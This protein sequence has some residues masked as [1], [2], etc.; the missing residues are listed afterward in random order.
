MWQDAFYLAVP[1]LRMV[2][3]RTQR[4][5]IAA[6]SVIVKIGNNLHAHHEGIT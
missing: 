4:V 6:L 2:I 3:Y 1:Q 5:F